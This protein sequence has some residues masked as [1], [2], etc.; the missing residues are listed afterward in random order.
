M[1]RGVDAYLQE[2]ELRRVE[3]FIHGHTYRAYHLGFGALSATL[4]HVHGSLGAHGYRVA[5]AET[6][7]RWDE[8]DGAPS[9]APCDSVVVET[10]TSD[11]G[12]L[13]PDFTVT[14]TRDGE[15]VGEC[16]NHSAGRY[17]RADAAQRTLF[18]VWLGISEE[19]Q[20]KGWGRHQLTHALS[21]G[22]QLGYRDAVISAD[23]RNYRALLLYANAGYTVA[24]TAYSFRADA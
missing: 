11:G 13:L 22:R 8:Y 23:A 24:N 3:A 12:G 2:R 6:F 1:L 17:S 9:H 20:G 21:V 18:T 5:D 7:L 16:A 14:A 10:N 15:A 19:W 4:G